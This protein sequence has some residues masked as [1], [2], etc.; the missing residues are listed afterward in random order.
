M[1][2]I[3]VPS[4]GTGNLNFPKEVV[5]KITIDEAI[6][7]LSTK[8]RGSLEFV[9]L[10]IFMQDTYKAFQD[11]L[12]QYS[13]Q[14]HITLPVNA[15]ESDDDGKITP[16]PMSL[17]R[18]RRSRLVGSRSTTLPLTTSGTSERQVFTIDNL[19]IELIIGD[20]TESTSDVIINPTN[21]EMKLNGAGVAGAILS[22]GGQEQQNLCDA[23]VSAIGMLDED[24]VVCTKATGKL[25]CKHIFHINYEGRDLKKL[26][27]VILT[28]LDKA[29]IMKM[30]SVAFPA[31][32]TG[33]NACQPQESAV[34]MLQ[35]FRTFV[36][37]VPLN[38]HQLQV[39][40]SQPQ[41]LQAFMY[42]FQHPEEAQP[43]IFTQAWN[44]LS[45][46]IPG[47]P[48]SN[49]DTPKVVPV[50][51]ELGPREPLEV[52]VYG[53]T[54]KA[55]NQAHHKLNCWISETLSDRRI[56]NKNI[57]NM[58]ETDEERLRK[59]SKNSHVEIDI[60]RDSSFIRLKGSRLS[61]DAVHTA[62]TESLHQYEKRLDKMQHAKQ[63]YEVVRW[64]RMDS[65]NSE[66]EE[67][68]EIPNY[69]I[70]MAHRAGKSNCTFGTKNDIDYFS[71]DFTTRKETD[72]HSGIV[73]KVERV[74]V[75]RQLQEGLYTIT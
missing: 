74:D 46:F 54:E 5:A 29:E 60:D 67:Y 34:G 31:V 61:V 59:I 62:L 52:V 41:V 58:S 18:V 1:I 37:S 48:S 17:A 50:M 10:V 26:S 12:S 6:S 7:F 69:E 53:E 56:N 64:R 2:S 71:V 66:G 44:Y 14:E 55:V 21:A 16:S 28:C 22:K 49:P 27:K 20:I 35:A 73:C 42:A 25:R 65:S 19:S 11:V 8:K 15:G 63:L 9:H 36:S 75:L 43:G 47:G 51:E 33:T 57:Q 30:T 45:S 40:V 70:E 3:A 72:H 39:V 68:E 32:G 13:S 38:L 24:K 23:V 4:I